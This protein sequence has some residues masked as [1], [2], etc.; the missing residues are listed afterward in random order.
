MR[1][2]RWP[3]VNHDQQPSIQ[4][5]ASTGIAASKIC[6]TTLHT[7]FCIPV[8][9]NLPLGRKKLLDL[10]EKYKFLKII[11]IDEMSMVGINDWNTF[12]NYLQLIKED[13]RPF[14]GVSILA[15][16]DLLQLPP[17]K[18]APV[19]GKVKHT[20]E[21]LTESIWKK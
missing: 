1:Y 15:S 17:V 7:A 5:T 4:R 9:N 21:S 2:L 3:G 20:L 8:H 14:G 16:G 6:G 11:I 10:R 13:D 12:E 18:Q 19:F